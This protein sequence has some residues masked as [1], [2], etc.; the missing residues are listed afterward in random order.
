[1]FSVPER[2]GT[3]SASLIGFPSVPADSGKRS[4]SSIHIIR[5]GID[6]REAAEF[7]PAKTM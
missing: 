2:R 6:E 7:A 5:K 3:F 4:T 1:M